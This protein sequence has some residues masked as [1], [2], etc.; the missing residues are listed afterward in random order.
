MVTALYMVVTCGIAVNFH[1]CMGEL[2]SVKV[3]HAQTDHCD[4]CGMTSKKSACCHDDTKWFKV[5]DNHQSAY[6]S[7]DFQ[8]PI[9]LLTPPERFIITPPLVSTTS[10]LVNNN[11]PPIIP[12]GTS[13]TILHCNFRI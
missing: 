13:L 8:A 7:V 12:G 11:S 4:D 5:D 1:Y 2:K 9:F 10:V 6:S 3:G